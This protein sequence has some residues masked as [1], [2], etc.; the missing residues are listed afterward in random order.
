LIVGIREAVAPA[1]A[2]FGR[3]ALVMGAVA[4]A[5]AVAAPLPVNAG[6]Y[7]DVT[8]IS[9]KPRQI[10]AGVLNVGYYD[11]GPSTAPAVF[12]LHGFPYDVHSYIDVAPVQ[13]PRHVAP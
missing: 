12:L 13:I 5:I 2:D 11:A 1:T 4:S 10:E 7:G 8:V 3:R 6:T 9:G